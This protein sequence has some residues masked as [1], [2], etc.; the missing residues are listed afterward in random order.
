MNLYNN[1]YGIKL[2]KIGRNNVLLWALLGKFLKKVKNL[3]H[4]SSLN[5]QYVN[6]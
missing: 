1:I 3:E 4:V 5:E 6:A 2:K